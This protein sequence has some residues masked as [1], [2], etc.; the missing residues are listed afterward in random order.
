MCEKKQKVAAASHNTRTYLE[1]LPRGATKA[2]IDA[3][4]KSSLHCVSLL[5]TINIECRLCRFT[6]HDVCMCVWRGWLGWVGKGGKMEVG[7]RECNSG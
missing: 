7:S 4:Q 1:V 5:T 2:E 3:T 6:G